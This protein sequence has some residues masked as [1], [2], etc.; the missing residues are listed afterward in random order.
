MRRAN[1]ELSPDDSSRTTLFDC[2][3]NN[4]DD[5]STVTPYF[6]KLDKFTIKNQGPEFKN[7]EIRDLLN[8]AVDRFNYFRRKFVENAC[9]DQA[10]PN[11]DR[12]SK[13]QL[14]VDV[15]LDSDVSDPNKIEL[16]SDEAYSVAKVEDDNLLWEEMRGL[17][18]IIDSEKQTISCYV[19]VSDE[20]IKEHFQNLSQS[21]SIDEIDDKAQN[22]SEKV[23]RKGVE[24][25]FN[26]NSC[27][28]EKVYFWKTVIE[29][30]EIAYKFIFVAVT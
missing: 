1:I 9:F 13:I 14:N 23:I 19:L 28:N 11:V 22:L 27:K 17:R 20:L 21:L 24:M 8:M 2:S 26:L 6:L 16:S 4:N 12:N 18:D 30:Q 5:S 25:Y 3:N 10:L 15:V 29:I 7:E